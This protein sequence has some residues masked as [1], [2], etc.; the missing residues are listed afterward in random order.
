MIAN[1]IEVFES[2]SE[3]PQLL[4]C[5]GLSRIVPAFEFARARMSVEDVTKI[6]E[7]WFLESIAKG[8]IENKLVKF[9]A[10]RMEDGNVKVSCLMY[11]VDPKADKQAINNQN[12]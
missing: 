4:K 12:Q 3:N 7:R 1:T 9:E 11:V 5:L 8:L 10:E 2:L 6:E